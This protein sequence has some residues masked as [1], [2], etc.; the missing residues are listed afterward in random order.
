L[1]NPLILNKMK[2]RTHYKK[3]TH[4]KSRRSK[5]VGKISA[6]G[7][8]NAVLGVA[9]G[10]AGAGLVTTKVLGSQSN[11]IKTVAALG[12]G[13]ITPMFW[14]SEL[15]K[16]AG[17]GMV[18]YGISKPLAKFGIA[19]VG[20]DETFEIPVTVAGD[21]S[22]IA[23]ADDFAMAGDEDFAMGY[24]DVSVIAGMDDMDM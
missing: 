12:L 16:F 17:A 8:I 5:S 3:T 14:K 6:G 10:V 19:G 7:A 1:Y 23:G 2:R 13:I 11:T 18:A 21:M 15:G 9:I 4:R 20:A 22:L 24:D